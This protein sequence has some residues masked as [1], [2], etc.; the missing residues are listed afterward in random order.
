MP[1]AIVFIKGEKWDFANKKLEEIMS[2]KDSTLI[3]KY[4]TV[5]E[6]YI[7]AFGNPDFIA[8]LWSTNLEH[9]KSSIIYIRNTCKV[10]TSSIV[11]VE[12]N[13]RQ[14]RAMELQE[15][16]GSKDHMELIKKMLKTYLVEERKKLKKIEDNIT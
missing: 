1:R 8:S 2:L 9:L 10:T 16:M 4:A 15:P 11:G 14:F 12:S 6:Y 5:L 7:E 13:E 3:K